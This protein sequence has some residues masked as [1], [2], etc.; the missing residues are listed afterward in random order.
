MSNAESSVLSELPSS[1]KGKVRAV[2]ALS[3]PI[4]GGMISQNL[5]NLVDIAM[6]GRLPNA[7]VALG[8]VG[9]GGVAC[10]LFSAFF[11]GMGPGVQA[12]ASRS[13]GEGIPRRAAEATVAALSVV[14]FFVIPYSQGVSLFAEDVFGVLASDPEVIEEGAPYLGIRLTAIPF[15]IAN[16]SFR[17]YW[18]GIGKTRV[19]LMTIVS[20]HVMNIFLNWVF[21]YGNLGAESL[22]V[23]GAG[24]ASVMAVSFGTCV[25][26]LIALAKAPGG[27]FFSWPARWGRVATRILRLAVPAGIQNGLFSMGFVAFYAIAERLGTDA[28]AA[29]NMII[30]LNLAAILPSLGFGLGAATLAGQAIGRKRPDEAMMW[31]RVTLG[32]AV[33]CM[34]A[35]GIA[36]VLF[37]EVW[38][39]ML[40]VDAETV[41]LAVGPLMLMGAMQPVD[42]IG[43]VLSQLLMGVGAVR[44]V[45]VYSVALQWGLFLPVA[46]YTCVAGEGDLFTLWTLFVCWRVLVAGAML[47]VYRRG[48]WVNVPV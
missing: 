42:C 3:L 47:Y 18:N 7:N 13:M 33:V 4:I 27:G 38:L 8:A 43:V 34:L 45:L 30:N 41:A 28:L 23:Y 24:L 26:I 36:L 6:V 39:S 29:T 1:T 11:M 44:T 15:V 46:Y 40:I 37:P 17:G 31:T 48:K 16:L 19:Y 2:L 32:I 22:G 10:W 14:V 25:Y 20:M 35:V 9:F 5:F 12:I 21:I